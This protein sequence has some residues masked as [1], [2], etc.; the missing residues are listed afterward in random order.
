MVILHLASISSLKIINIF[1]LINF[2]IHNIQIKINPKFIKNIHNKLT[3][4][5]LN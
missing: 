2:Y 5:M 1:K 3:C 4:E